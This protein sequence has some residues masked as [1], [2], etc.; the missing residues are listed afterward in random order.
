M[1]SVDKEKALRILN[2]DAEKIYSLINSQ[3][4]HL[5]FASC[6]AFEEVV[7]TQLYGF[8]KQVEYAVK[9]GILPQTEGQELLSNLET[10][11]N[12]MYTTYYEENK[13]YLQHKG[14]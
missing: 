1:E 10:S 2:D 9:L 7:D 11:L 13:P 3:K 4:E 5:C 8:S 14:E 12:R 6:P